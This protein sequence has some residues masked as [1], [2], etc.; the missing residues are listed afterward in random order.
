CVG[1]ILIGR[2]SFSFIEWCKRSVDWSG[3]LV[4]RLVALLTTLHGAWSKAR[5]MRRADREALTQREAPHIELHDKDEA[6]LMHLEEDESDWIPLDMTGEP[7]LAVSE[8]L[9]AGLADRAALSALQEEILTG[10]AP[11]VADK[12]AAKKARK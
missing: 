11:R 5:A 7:P 3:L 6:I 10:S 2:S 1:L 9:R 8:S 12:P 4:Q